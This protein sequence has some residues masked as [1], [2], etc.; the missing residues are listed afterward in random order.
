MQK[1]KT[2][3]RKNYGQNLSMLLEQ[4]NSSPNSSNASGN[5]NKKNAIAEFLDDF[6]KYYNQPPLY[7]NCLVLSGIYRIINLNLF[8]LC[9]P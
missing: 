3:K 9:F 8:Y 4:K 5:S 2:G 7:S 1:Q 6:L